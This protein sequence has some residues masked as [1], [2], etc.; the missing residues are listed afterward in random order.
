MFS[1]VQLKIK[2]KHFFIFIF[3]ALKRNDRCIDYASE[4]YCP[5]SHIRRKHRWQYQQIQGNMYLMQV[6]IYDYL[7]F[8]SINHHI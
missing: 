3:D 4:Q 2:I 7:Q 1:L 6:Q 5:C 8:Y